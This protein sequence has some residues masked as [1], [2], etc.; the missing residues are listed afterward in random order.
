MGRV[1]SSE[2]DGWTP[3]ADTLA[4]RKFKLT[5]WGWFPEEDGFGA[6]KS[7]RLASKLICQTNEYFDG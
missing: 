3:N 4:K 1:V 7:P 2:S 6:C 5:P